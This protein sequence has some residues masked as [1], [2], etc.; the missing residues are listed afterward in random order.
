MFTLL[1]FGLLLPFAF[2]SVPFGLLITW[3]AGMG[4]IRAIGSGNVGATNVLRTGKKG[5][6]IATLLCDAGKGAL[7]VFIAD[8]M[9]GGNSWLPLIAG[10]VAILGHIFSP[11]L[12][13]KGG[14]GVA[15]SIGVILALSWP[16]GVCAILVW[17]FMAWKFRYSSLAALTAAAS[18]PIFALIFAD[19]KLA[20]AYLCI[21]LLVA[22]HHQENIK[23]LQA[24]TES[25]ISFGK[26]PDDQ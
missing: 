20:I 17:V 19:W 12:G 5:L 9:G 16:V 25:Q 11:W 21:A 23:R 22:S 13:F 1:I 7:A 4:D 8:A 10:V 26:K 2:G 15:T 3:S 6:A 24:G 18:T 14:K